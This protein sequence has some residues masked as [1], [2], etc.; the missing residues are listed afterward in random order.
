M[1]SNN[2]WKENQQ[3]EIEATTIPPTHESRIG[4]RD[5]PFTGHLIPRCAR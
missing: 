1:T 4:D 5:A 3:A 2:D